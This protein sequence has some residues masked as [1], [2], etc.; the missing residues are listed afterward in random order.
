NLTVPL[1]SC[2][3]VIA[4]ILSLL[5]GEDCGGVEPA[6]VLP[7]P[8]GSSLVA[9]GFFSVGGPRRPFGLDLPDGF[10]FLLSPPGLDGLALLPCA[11]LM[12][13]T[14]HRVP[15]VC[16]YLHDSV[17]LLRSPWSGSSPCFPLL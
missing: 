17:S 7:T 4:S 14:V 6:K 11:V 5:T 10:L 9:T 8:A 2:T 15:P 13:S 1:V 16:D 12:S 3:F